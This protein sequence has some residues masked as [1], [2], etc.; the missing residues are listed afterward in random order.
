MSII[1][2]RRTILVKTGVET[3]TA[4]VA[5]GSEG[6]KASVPIVVLGALGAA[7]G[8]ALWGLYGLLGGALAGAG[9]GLSV[10]KIAQRKAPEPRQIQS[11]GYAGLEPSQIQPLVNT[12]LAPLP[13]TSPA[14]SPSSSS[15]Y[16][17]SAIET[18]KVPKIDPSKY[19]PPA[20]VAT[21]EKPS[22]F[23]FV[24]DPVKPAT[25]PYASGDYP[26]GPYGVNIGE[27][28]PNAS[29]MGYRDG[30][31][32]YAPIK[33]S[34]YYDPTGDRGIKAVLV[35][36]A[37]STCAP[38][39]DEFMYLP[40]L[41][42][43]YGPQGAKFLVALMD[44]SPNEGKIK[45]WLTYTKVPYPKFEVASTM[46][47]PFF[48]SGSSLD[49]PKNT[50]VDP[51]TMKVVDAWVGESQPKTSKALAALIAKNA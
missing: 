51:R 25:T 31:N 40:A 42:D 38:C 20:Y 12:D 48:P 19:I 32:V 17:A 2:R 8:G 29:V 39:K 41:F 47:Q 15:T 14:G 26:A 10:E 11:P 50:I 22:P 30:L 5:D 16:G 24:S 34:D 35:D 23:P 21:P 13:A 1:L 37:L 36:A 18:P 27:T 43:T 46:V 6:L 7:F 3:D 4:T 33:M 28:Y 45:T 44:P 9:A 49:T